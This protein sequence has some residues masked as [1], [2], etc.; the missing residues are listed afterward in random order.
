VTAGQK[1]AVEVRAPVK[2]GK[3]RSKA[4]PKTYKKADR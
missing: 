1:V 2:K 4:K 3:S